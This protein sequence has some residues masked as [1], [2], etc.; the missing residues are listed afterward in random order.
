MAQEEPHLDLGGQH[1]DRQEQQQDPATEAEADHAQQPEL[2][3]AGD[4]R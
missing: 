2:R 4:D 3:L 1:D